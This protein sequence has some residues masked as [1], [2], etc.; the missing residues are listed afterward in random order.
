MFRKLRTAAV[1][2]AKTPVP[3]NTLNEEILTGEEVALRLKVPPTTVYEWTRR[4]NRRPIP[5]HRAGKY[6][7]FYFSEVEKWL[8]GEAVG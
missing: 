4:R 1:L 5:N 7:R 3:S 6:L 2:P 8:R